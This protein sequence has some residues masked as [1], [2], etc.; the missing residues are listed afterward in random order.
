MI[1]DATQALGPN[2]AM[3]ESVAT[4]FWSASYC[5]HDWRNRQQKM[6]GI[7]MVCDAGTPEYELA[8]FLYQLAHQRAL[9]EPSP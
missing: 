3:I 8:E 9:L 1:A 7:R 6:H 4:M 2:V 5:Y